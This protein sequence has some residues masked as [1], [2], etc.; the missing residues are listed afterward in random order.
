MLIVD[1][2][3]KV[4]RIVDGGLKSIS[5]QNKPC[6]T[7][8]LLLLC[9]SLIEGYRKDFIEEKEW[10]KLG[11]EATNNHFYNDMEV[12]M[13]SLYFMLLYKLLFPLSLILGIKA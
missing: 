3:L 11:M 13:P 1:G 8:P 6:M 5:Y 10:K 9:H 7:H 2:V 4:E 12:V